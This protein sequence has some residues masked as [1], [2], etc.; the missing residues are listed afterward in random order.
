MSR[1]PLCGLPETQQHINVACLHPPL[2]EIRCTHRRS[3]D[4]FF[5]MY[6][7]QHFPPGQRWIAPVMDYVEDHIWANSTLDGDIWNGRWLP[8]TFEDLIPTPPDFH[9][10]T[11]DVQMALTWLRRLTGLLQ[12]AQQEIFRA[13]HIELM[14]KEA[15]ALRERITKLRKRHH[16]RKNRTLYKAWRLPYFK[17]PNPRRRFALP[18]PALEQPPLAVHQ[19]WTQY[20][21]AISRER[22]HDTRFP[23][24]GGHP[25][26]H[27]NKQARPETNKTPETMQIKKHF[28]TLSIIG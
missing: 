3:I 28:T 1:C 17:P 26:H 20:S 16:S 25:F 21:S 13:R 7:H 23:T 12:R 10:P 15:K 4:E 2:T 24:T 27:S 5:Q 14:S 22:D 18:P 6:R 19:L 9:L 8:S 11:T